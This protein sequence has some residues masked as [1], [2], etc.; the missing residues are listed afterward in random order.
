MISFFLD[1]ILKGFQNLDT[2][3]SSIFSNLIKIFINFKKFTI[4][5][6]SDS[7][8]SQEGITGAIRLQPVRS[9]LGNPHITYV[10]L[11]A[12]LIYLALLPE[13]IS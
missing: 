4:N 13:T 11:V 6:P 3:K 8:Q 10:A 7:P 12:Y 5:F 9:G 2:R 1:F